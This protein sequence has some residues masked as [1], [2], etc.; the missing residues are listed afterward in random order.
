MHPDEWIRSITLI[1]VLLA[2]VIVLSQSRGECEIPGSSYVPCIEFEKLWRSE[3]APSARQFPSPWSAEQIPHGYVI[4]DATGQALAY[5]YYGR[6]QQR[7]DDKAGALTM[8]EARRIAT[9]IAKLPELM[10]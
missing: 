4:K 3:T 1:V 2:L 9:N 7:D 6:E 8:K 10:D 5:V